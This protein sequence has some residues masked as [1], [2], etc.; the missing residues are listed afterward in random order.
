MNQDKK[1]TARIGTKFLFGTAK[2]VEIK[3]L[4]PQDKR[5]KETFL[6]HS[7]LNYLKIF[8][9]LDFKVISNPDDSFGDHDVLI[10]FKSRK[11]IGIQVTELTFE[12]ERARVSIRKS[13]LAKTLKLITESN[14]NSETKKIFQIIVPES[15]SI[16][17]DIQKPSKILKQISENLN[18]TGLIENNGFKLLITNVSEDSKFY[19]PHFNNIGIDVTFDQ[20]S[21]T[22]EHYLICIDIIFCKKL[23]SKSEWLLIWSTDFWRDKAW[24]K[25]DINDYMINKFKDSSF[26]NVFFL[27]S[28]DNPEMFLPNLEIFTIK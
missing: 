24:I 27:E 11:Q 21:T 26:S 28:F 1:N 9:P 17:P 20:I 15:D 22:L 2:Q 7:L 5:E 13:F 12:L 10:E 16:K 23:K 8:D 6:V 14:I 18:K 19:V 25:D 4:L 3:K